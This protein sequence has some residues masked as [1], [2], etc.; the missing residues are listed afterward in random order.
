MYTNICDTKR[1]GKRFQFNSKSD[2]LLLK[3]NMRKVFLV[4]LYA[5]FYSFKN[6]L[7]RLTNNRQYRIL[8]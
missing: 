4:V 5:V 8:L 7:F 6:S 1:R 3:T 2:E